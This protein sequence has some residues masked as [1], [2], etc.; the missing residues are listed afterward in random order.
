VKEQ[1]QIDNRTARWENL[2][3]PSWAWAPY[4][5]DAQRPWSLELAA[6]LY[7]RA[8]FG[9][10]WGELQQ[11]LADGPELAVGKLLRP[12]AGAAAFNEAYDAYENAG[13]GSEGGAPAWWL[14]RLIQTP[15]PVLEQMTLFWHNHFAITNA[16]V[17][18]PEMMC[19]YVHL[20][21]RN[22]LG[23]FDVLLE[24]VLDEPAV[25][26]C[27]GARANRKARP[28]LD[29]ARSLMEQFTLGPG[30][31]SEQDVQGAARALTGWFV[32]QGKAHF[33]PREHDQGAKKLLGREGDFDRKDLLR[34][35]LEQPAT[36][37]LV[38]RK[39]HRWFV[40]ETASLPDALV[41]PLAADFAKDFDAGKLVETVLRS[42]LFFSGYRQKIKSPV[43]YAV[44]L[45]RGLEATVG[46]VRL[47]A[48]LADLGQDLFQPPTLKGWAGGQHWINRFTLLGRAR[49]AEELLAGSGPYGGKLDPAATAS[50][51]GQSG[52]E[53]ASR[54]LLQL[55]LQGD[56]P[57]KTR[58]ALLAGQAPGPA[59]GPDS[60]RR[61]GALLA[62]LPEWHLA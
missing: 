23:R 60:L 14:R 55:F 40:S 58:Q 53:A 5:P 27:L 57:E 47:A 3:D 45:V 7:R 33:I 30:R 59:Q 41:A 48:D 15:C 39:L 37:Q 11:A 28:S 56:L 34:L 18:N 29:F 24:S 17:N 21:R 26:V 32:S 22:A 13:T 43:Q 61:F 4:R 44:G 49:L 52:P 38:V 50:K 25:L 19:R 20:L 9:A 8:A 31:F 35:L 1:A 42:N 2:D 12:K 46:T 6:H 36:A 16:R 51:Y 54:F 62:A 10:N